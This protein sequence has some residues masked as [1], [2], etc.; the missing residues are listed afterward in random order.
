LTG[1]FVDHDPFDEKDLTEMGEVEIAVEFGRGSDFTGFD[2]PMVR[3]IESLEVGMFSIVEEQHQVVKD[4]G[5]IGFDDE[6]GLSLI[7]QVVSEFALG[8]QGIGGDV[9]VFKIEAVEQRDRHTD[10]VGLF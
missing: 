3:R 9:G 5:L 6:V 8:E 4:R 1:F 2:A 10:L 7:D